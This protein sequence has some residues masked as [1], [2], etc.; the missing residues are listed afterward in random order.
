MLSEKGTSG[1]RQQERELGGACAGRMAQ[2][3]V[4][5]LLNSYRP[6]LGEKRFQWRGRLVRLTSQNSRKADS[7]ASSPEVQRRLNHTWY[8]KRDLFIL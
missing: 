8:C 7:L 5:G 6:T 2:V 1:V 3:P 4:P